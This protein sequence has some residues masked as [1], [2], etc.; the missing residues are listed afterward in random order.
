M[1]RISFLLLVFCAALALF[2]FGCGESSTSA[3]ENPLQGQTINSDTNSDGS[4]DVEALRA[5][6]TFICHFANGHSGFVIEVGT[7][8]VPKHVANHGDCVNFTGARVQRASCNCGL[9]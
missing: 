2:S 6:R 3:V 1:N 8:S 9:D 4:S 5:G 7:P